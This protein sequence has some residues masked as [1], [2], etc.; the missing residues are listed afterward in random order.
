MG[1]EEYIKSD[2]GK[3]RLDRVSRSNKKTFRVVIVCTVCMF[4]T[5]LVLFPLENIPDEIIAGNRALQIYRIASFCL[6]AL[7]M[8]FFCGFLF[9]EQRRIRVADE[10]LKK[11]L[12]LYWQE[13]PIS[14]DNFV[15]DRELIVDIENIFS[16]GY[17]TTKKGNL[18]EL[19]L[20]G[21]RG[22]VV[23]DMTLWYGAM[24]G[25]VEKF[26]A[27]S[28]I[29]YLKQREMRGESFVTVRIVEYLYGKRTTEKKD[30]YLVKQGKYTKEG[31]ALVKRYERMKMS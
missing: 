11:A 5:A 29:L 26:I 25:A 21:V 31:V 2:E 19:I 7:S 24:D 30:G 20:T 13:N 8:V 10:M 18:K 16:S 9:F 1:F 14:W 23:L 4:L 28:L 17:G 6:A 15:Q 27:S 12:S 3:E 22:R